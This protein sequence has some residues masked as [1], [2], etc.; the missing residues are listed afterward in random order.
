MFF[1][2]QKRK[3]LKSI[4]IKKFF[5]IWISLPLLRLFLFPISFHALPA[6]AQC[7]SLHRPF[8]SHSTWSSTASTFKAVAVLRLLRGLFFQLGTSPL[9]GHLASIPHQRPTVAPPRKTF[10]FVKQRLRFFFLAY[11]S[12]PCPIKSHNFR[13][14]SIICIPIES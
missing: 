2:L 14:I 1:T 6:A 12:V 7:N 5:N 8:Q 13:R 9:S 10:L 11:W 3:V 4:S